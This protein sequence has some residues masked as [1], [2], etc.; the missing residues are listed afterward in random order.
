MGA[1]VILF[2]DSP[3]PRLDASGSPWESAR[4]RAQMRFI[5][6]AITLTSRIA[7]NTED[8]SSQRG[9]QNEKARPALA[10]LCAVLFSNPDW[11]CM[12][13]YCFSSTVS[14]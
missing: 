6:N 14:L 2:H 5:L 3:R 12:G 8:T 10:T 11:S 1:L 9:R 13:R 4:V 7:L